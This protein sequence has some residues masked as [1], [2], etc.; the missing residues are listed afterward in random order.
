M[1]G[2]F[3]AH[4]FQWYSRHLLF[5]AISQDLHVAPFS[6]DCCKY[7]TFDFRFIAKKPHIQSVQGMQGGE[8]SKLFT[9]N[10]KAQKL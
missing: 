8:H 5:V 2:A 10:P 7:C 9:I 1:I 4:R 6:A 3:H